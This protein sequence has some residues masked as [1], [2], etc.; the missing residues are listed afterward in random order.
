[1][2]ML[3]A[4]FDGLPIAPL[5]AITPFFKMRVDTLIQKID[6][7][8]IRLPYFRL[9]DSQKAQRHVHL[10]DLAA[11]IDLRHAEAQEEFKK[12]WR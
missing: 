9:D 12:L 10:T 6:E 8:V 4:H 1:M 5:E 7:G 11:L 3:T 2:Q